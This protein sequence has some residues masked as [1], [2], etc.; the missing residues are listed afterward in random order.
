MTYILY[1]NCQCPAT[2]EQQPL[3]LLVRINKHH[4]STATS[5][6]TYL[7]SAHQWRGGR[8]REGM[9]LLVLFVCPAWLVDKEG[10]GGEMVVN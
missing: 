3:S 1:T 5:K 8:K 2:I 10:K 4:Y 6:I 7:G 9:V